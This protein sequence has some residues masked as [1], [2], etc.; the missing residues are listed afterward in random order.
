MTTD[1][2]MEVLNKYDH[3]IT[4]VVRKYYA[5]AL[6]GSCVGFDDLKQ[7][8][9]IAALQWIRQYESPEDVPYI[10]KYAMINAMSRLCVKNLCFS[11]PER[12]NDHS[13]YQFVDRSLLR[14]A[15]Q[16]IINK[17]TLSYCVN[18]DAEFATI[19]DTKDFIKSL[20]APDSEMLCLRMQGYTHAEIAKMCHVD[21]STV[22][23]RLKRL[24]TRFRDGVEEVSA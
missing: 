21:D 9:V 17:A 24:A 1:Q 6:R 2:E 8:A 10:S 11:Y 14:D 16:E 5:H 19:I 4:D 3:I 22:C 23:R 15:K 18:Y 13:F 20:D 7:E 12:T